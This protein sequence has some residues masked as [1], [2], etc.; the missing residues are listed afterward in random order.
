MKDSKAGRNSP[1]ADGSGDAADGGAKNS[2]SGGNFPVSAFYELDNRVFQ[3]NWSIPYKVDES[4]ASCL[5]AA[6][7]LA[8]EN[9]MGADEYCAKFH[10]RI[11]PEAFKKLLASHA[12]Q[13]WG[14]EIQEG[15]YD[16]LELFLDLIVTRL[17]AEEKLV[18]DGGG[19]GDGSNSATVEV[20]H[21][22]LREAIQ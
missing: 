6:T 8:Q 1:C 16:M 9:L 2:D 5:R 21:L 18:R 22:M 17:A 10:D 19:G 14:Q 15:I 3:D 20:P 12:T 4:F 13:R 11:L 7:K